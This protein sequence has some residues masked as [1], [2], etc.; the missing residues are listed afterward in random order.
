MKH[1]PARGVMISLC[2]SSIHRRKLS[3]IYSHNLTQPRT[4]SPQS[5]KQISQRRDQATPINLSGLSVHLFTP[6][7]ILR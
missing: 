6:L 5:C 1:Y 7:E 3:Q 2:W 4:Q